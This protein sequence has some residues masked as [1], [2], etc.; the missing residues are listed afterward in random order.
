MSWQIEL[1]IGDLISVIVKYGAVMGKSITEKNFEFIGGQ[2][3]VL[4]PCRSFNINCPFNC[5][6]WREMDFGKDDNELFIF[7]N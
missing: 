3:S 7:S 2:N 1:Y 6:A 5:L 4:N